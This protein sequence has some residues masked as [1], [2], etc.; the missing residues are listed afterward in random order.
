MRFKAWLKANN[1]TMESFHKLSGMCTTSIC[2]AS[3]GDPMSPKICKKI[4]EF[5]N[6]QVCH[7][8]KVKLGV[9]RRVPFA[10]EQKETRTLWRMRRNYA[11]ARGSDWPE[12]WKTFEGF[13][14][15]MGLLP[16]GMKT[17]VK[18]SNGFPYSKVNFM[19]KK[20]KK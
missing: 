8:F 12:N 16:D 4:L 11:N 18:K 19:W 15:E 7:P 17:F 5:T 10:P 2:R 1:H 20:H 9:V 13:V 14:A 6:G 3:Q